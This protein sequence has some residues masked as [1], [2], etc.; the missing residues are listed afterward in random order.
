MTKDK[1]SLGKELVATAL[2]RGNFDLSSGKKSHYFLDKYLFETEPRLLS[3]VTKY[4]SETIPPGTQRL[5][6]MEIGAVP[7][8]TAL[9]LKTGL[10]FVIVR[11]AKK[12]YG[13][14]R[15]IEGKINQGDT[16][17]LVEDVVTTGHQAIKAVQILKEAGAK[18]IKVI[19]VI[20]REEG[21]RKNIESEGLVFEALF[22]KTGLGI[23]A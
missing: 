9:S 12:E 7:L 22:T 4:L 3:W 10:P 20:D 2:L 11:K 1:D 19:C 5:A 18:V 6:G 8:A 15:L 16:V 13:T 14:A 21:G 17:V 23:S